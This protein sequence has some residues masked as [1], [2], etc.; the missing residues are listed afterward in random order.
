MPLLRLSIQIRRKI[1]GE[2]HPA[3]SNSLNNLAGIL[4]ELHKYTEAAP[5]MEQVWGWFRVD[6]GGS[7]GVWG[8]RVR[9]GSLD[10]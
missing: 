5:L 10:S 8:A 1:L 2:M 3:T 7:G 6:Q 9:W 4:M